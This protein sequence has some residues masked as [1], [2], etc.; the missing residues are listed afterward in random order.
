MITQLEFDM[1]SIELE[2]SLTSDPMTRK[3][4][5]G[6]FAADQLRSVKKGTISFPG[7]Y[8]CNTDPSYKP[9]THWVCI[10][11][12]IDQDGAAKGEYFCSYGKPPISQFVH[13]LHSHT[14]TWIENKFRL[15][16]DFSSVCGSYVLYF[17]YH[18]SRS[19]S[20]KEILSD[21]TQDFINNDAYVKM[22]VVQRYGEVN[23]DSTNEN[24]KAFQIAVNFLS[25]FM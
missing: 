25:G 19:R 11:L 10:Y 20:F 13:F 14:S 16:S 4:F 23:F 9:G 8:V 15:Q 6:V 5:K 7:L 3:L 2:L 17:A 22:F 21:F 1:N 18:R 24:V 12:F